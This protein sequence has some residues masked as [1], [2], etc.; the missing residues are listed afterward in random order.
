MAEPSHQSKRKVSLLL[1]GTLS[2]M[3]Q[4]NQADWDLPH[5]KT[6]IVSNVRCFHDVW[7]LAAKN[8]LSTMALMKA[9]VLWQH[10]IYL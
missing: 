1:M 9:F 6:L 8:L 4:S 3:R 7:G 2:G 10:W 5:L